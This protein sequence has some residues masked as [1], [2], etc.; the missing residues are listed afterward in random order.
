MAKQP[1]KK[2]QKL[3]QKCTYCLRP[4]QSLCWCLLRFGKREAGDCRFSGVINPAATLFASWAW[5][6]YPQSCL[7]FALIFRLVFWSMMQLWWLE[8]IHRRMQLDNKPLAEV[9]PVAVDGVVINYFSHV[10]GHCCIITDGLC[11]W[12]NGACMSPIP[13]MPRWVCSFLCLL[14]LALPRGW[15]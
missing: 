3:M 5:G 9:I 1:T 4:Y 10:Y 13:L 2:A 6:F 11:Q 15:L 7:L 14:P 8:N 12:F